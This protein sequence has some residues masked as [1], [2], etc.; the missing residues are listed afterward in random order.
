MQIVRDV[1][2]AHDVA[3]LDNLPRWEL[4]RGRELDEFRSLMLD[5]CHVNRR[6]NM[7]WGLDVCRAFEAPL[8]DVNVPAL[9]AALP[10]QRKIDEW[11]A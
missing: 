6:G 11:M 3:L 7:L 4:L 5:P 9:A 2:A 1:A 10:L 8:S